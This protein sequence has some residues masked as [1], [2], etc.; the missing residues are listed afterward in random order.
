[1]TFDI[2][3][4]VGQREEEPGLS[5]IEQGIV[6]C[7]GQVDMVHNNGIAVQM[8]PPPPEWGTDG[9]IACFSAVCKLVFFT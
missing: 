1:M 8:N 3:K 7:C 2:G 9:K 5:V 4:Y 6:G